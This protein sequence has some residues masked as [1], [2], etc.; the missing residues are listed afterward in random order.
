MRVST[1]SR[2][3]HAE[4]RSINADEQVRVT[5]LGVPD[6]EFR[7]RSLHECTQPS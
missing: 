6:R 3:F 2:Q 4:H 5:F 7:H 1:Y